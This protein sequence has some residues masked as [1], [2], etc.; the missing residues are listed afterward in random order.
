MFPFPRPDVSLGGFSPETPSATRPASSSQPC[1]PI[2]DQ[3][4]PCTFCLASHRPQFHPAWCILHRQLHG[5]CVSD[6]VPSQVPL[7]PSSLASS[8][9]GGPGSH[10]EE[11]LCP[12]NA[13]CFPKPSHLC[14]GCSVHL[15]PLSFTWLTPAYPVGISSDTTSVGYLSWTPGSVRSL[16]FALTMT[17]ASPIT[18]FVCN[19][20]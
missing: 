7:V 8:S 9:S 2:L 6:R 18:A 12:L 13:P 15:S 5:L 1:H 10:Q 20:F 17:H 3:G 14:T 4:T 16:F 19:P 11:L